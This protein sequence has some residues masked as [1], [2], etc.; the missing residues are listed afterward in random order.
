MLYR[1]AIN[2]CEYKIIQI[3]QFILCDFIARK[4]LAI[5]HRICVRSKTE[6]IKWLTYSGPHTAY[7][8]DINLLVALHDTLFL[9]RLLISKSHTKSSGTLDYMNIV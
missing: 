7:Y 6:K 4:I 5:W 2:L 9:S 8:Q 1:S 3:G